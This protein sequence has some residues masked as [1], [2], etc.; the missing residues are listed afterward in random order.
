MGARVSSPAAPPAHANVA[1][2]AS[3]L[4]APESLLA[5]KT[6]SSDCGSTKST[7]VSS[8]SSIS[9]SPPNSNRG[10]VA[11][12]QPQGDSTSELDRGGGIT[13]EPA[14]EEGTFELNMNQDVLADCVR[15]IFEVESAL[16]HVRKDLSDM[17]HHGAETQKQLDAGALKSAVAAELK[18]VSATGQK[19]DADEPPPPAGEEQVEYWD[20]CAR[21]TSQRNTVRL[22]N[23]SFD[24]ALGLYQE[25]DLRTAVK[26]GH[27][28]QTKF[29][30]QGP[31]PTKREQLSVHDRITA[32]LMLENDDSA[33][34]RSSKEST[35]DECNRE[36]AP[37]SCGRKTDLLRCGRPGGGSLNSQLCCQVSAARDP[38]F[39]E[40]VVGLCPRDS[41]PKVPNSL[42]GREEEEE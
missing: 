30:P 10:A 22:N 26:T 3:L 29:R 35:S 14:G 19:S 40:Q 31:R 39:D 17:Y 38:S 2:G 25:T 23:N 24:S 16:S 6:A 27:W 11:V 36:C 28:V 18:A 42:R 12:P 41:R 20:L 13:H 34:S 5:E 32:P 37:S 21:R 9:S 8:S 15:K 33:S 4:A 1:V 7:T